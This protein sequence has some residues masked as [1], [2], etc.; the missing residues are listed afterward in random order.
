MTSE[1]RDSIVVEG[2]TL[3]YGETVALRGIDFR[4][5]PGEIIGFLGPNGAGKTTTMKILTGYLPAEQGSVRVA[6]FE[7]GQKV[8]EVRRRVG[9]LPENV[10]L[11]E[12]MLVYDY[13]HFVAS[14]R[15]VAKAKRENRVREVARLTGIEA[16][17]GRAISELS[18]GYRQ[19]V[20]LAQAIIHEPDV[21][22]LDE[23]TTGLDPNQIV[24]IRDV[25]KEIGREKTVI[26]STHILQE[27]TAVCDRIILLHRGEIVGDGGLDELS[28]RVAGARGTTVVTFAVDERW[29]SEEQ[30]RYLESIP[31]V[32]AVE[33]IHVDRGSQEFRV[34]STDPDGVRL[35]LMK[36][37]VESP[38]G[39]IGFQCGK[40]TLEEVF[41]AFTTGALR[42]EPEESEETE[43]T[44]E[45]E[46]MELSHG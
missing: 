30:R 11:Y 29:S 35:E 42:E 28:E 5:R 23:P 44:E 45:T 38:R 32:E 7:V 3:K 20:G 14:M 21:L 43:E 15:E 24:E 4:V 31:G 39:L 19:R 27:V 22:I 17:L 37:E 12:D 18:K 33:E 36:R 16:M 8:M 1:E 9:Y 26:F 10:P 25:I 41:R 40:P 34:E 13:L 6:G 2:L 46:E